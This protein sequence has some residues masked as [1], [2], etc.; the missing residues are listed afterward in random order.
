MSSVVNSAADKKFESVHGPLDF[1]S[2]QTPEA[3]A[4]DDGRTRLTFGELAERVRVPGTAVQRDGVSPK[5]IWIDGACEPTSQ[6]VR[7]LATLQADHVAAVEDPDWPDALRQRVKD[8][9][10]ARLTLRQGWG[11]GLPVDSFYIGFTSGSTG[12]PKAFVRSHR[13]WTHSFEACIRSFGP[14]AQTALL[15]PG[16]LSH[17]LF[18]FGALLGLWTGG[19]VRLQSGFSAGAAMRVLLE[20]EALSLIAVPSQLLLM[21]EYA[22]RHGLRAVDATRLVMISGAPWPRQRTPELKALFPNA[23]IVEFYGASETSFV[24]WVDS[25]TDLPQSAVGRPFA[26]VDLRIVS[27]DPVCGIADAKSGTPGLVYVRSPMLFTDYVGLDPSSG[28]GGV[29]RHG[30]WISVGDIGHVDS[31][32][33]LHLAGRAQRMFVTR[34]KNLFPEEVEQVLATHPSVAE[35][36]VQPVPD[37]LRGMRTVALLQLRAPAGR[38]SLVDWCRVRLESYKTPSRFI[39]CDFWPRTTSGKTDHKALAQLLSRQRHASDPWRT[40]EWE[41]PG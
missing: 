9:L 17:S 41:A 6:L 8:R 26:D 15:V 38:A 36:S 29:L 28:Q 30:E 14:A 2:T 34:G 7:V 31:G 25:A 33:F 35:V 12:L 3:I 18:L 4:I 5:V 39:V 21:L 19:G 24:A 10:N 23:R 40:L 32:G 37:A 11:D 13:S 20:G 27:S 1:W 16:R 22:S